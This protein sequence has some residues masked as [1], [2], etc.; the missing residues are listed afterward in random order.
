[1]GT[2]RVGLARVQ[3]LIENLKR[4]LDLNASTLKDV[5][6]QLGRDEIVECS[7]AAHT[8]TKAQTGCVVELHRGAGSTVT[9]PADATIGLRYTF[10]VRTI[11]G[12]G[13]YVINVGT[14][15]TFSTSSF[16]V[17]Q[18]NTTSAHHAIVR[19]NDGEDVT[20][21]MTYHGSNKTAQLGTMFE[22][23]CV[24]PKKWRITGNHHVDGTGAAVFA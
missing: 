9:L 6:V 22:I 14:N 4:E 17:Q 16:I 1:M 2:K 12:S 8:L 21:T 20:L 11:L 5:N 24:A 3:A 13:A 19:P 10:M 7:T 23:E 18:D 15:N